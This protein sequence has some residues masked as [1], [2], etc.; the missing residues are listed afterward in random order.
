MAE[1]VLCLYDHIK[2]IGLYLRHSSSVIM[3]RFFVSCSRGFAAYR[4]FRDHAGRCLLVPLQRPSHVFAVSTY[5]DY[6]YERPFF[7]NN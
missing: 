5:V 2:D 1:S 6:L 4:K 3:L 7:T